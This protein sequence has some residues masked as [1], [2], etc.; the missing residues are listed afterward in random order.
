MIDGQ[1][2][3]GDVSGAGR[4][5]LINMQEGSWGYY[6]RTENGEWISYETFQAFPNLDLKDP[7]VK[8]VDLTGDGLADI[9]VYSEQV[10]TWF[11]SLGA[12]GYGEGQSVTQPADENKGPTCVFSDSEE[13]IYLADIS[14]DGLADLVRIRNGDV[15][16]WPSLGYCRFGAAVQMDNGPWFDCVDQFNENRVV[17]ADVDGS[18]TT[19]ILYLTS[20]GVDI[21]LNQ[22][23]NGFSE[24]KSLNFLPIDDQSSVRAVDLLGNG[25]TCLVWSTDL[26][27]QYPSM[28][29]V[30]LTRGKK[31]HLLTRS[32]NNLGAESRLYYAPSTKFYLQD[33]AKGT[34]WLTS[35]PFPVQCVEKYEVFDHISGNRFVTQFSYHHGYF[36]GCER[37]FR[38]FA[39]TEAWDTETFASVN[40]KAT[41]LDSSLHIPP[42]HTKT[43]FHCGSYLENEKLRQQLALEYF[44]A[45]ASMDKNA[46]D[47]FYK[48]LLGFPIMPEGDI[49]A[50]ELRES[51]RA[52]KGMAIRVES[53]ADDGSSKAHL[54]YNIIESNYIVRC[55]QP[56][57]DKN[58]HSIY[59]VA[60][61]ESITHHY[62]RNIE[63]PRVQHSIA[64]D[65]NYYGQVQKSISIGYGR[66]SGQSS[67]NAVDKLKQETTMFVYSET[68]FTNDV[69]ADDDYRMRLPY[70]SRQYELSGF[71]LPAGADRFSPSDFSRNDFAPISSLVEV[72]Y[73]Q[74]NDLMTKKKRLLG[75]SITVYRSD[76]LERLL[77]FG[78]LESRGIPGTS[79]T[80]CFTPGL[81]QKLFIRQIPGQSPENLLPSPKDVLQGTGDQQGGYV[82]LENNGHYWKKGGKVSFHGDPTA[83]PSAELVEAKGHFFKPRCFTDAFGNNS[84]VDYDE[85]IL[86]PVV[87]RDA[88]GN[89]ASLIM[90]YRVLAPRM[91]TNINGNRS[92]VAFDTLGM[93][94]ASAIMGKVSENLGDSFDNF[95]ADIS[96][97]NLDEFFANPRGQIAE[98]IL[99]TATMRTV[100]DV[101]RYY[102][103]PDRKL[104][105]YS[106]VISRES[107][108]KDPVSADGLKLQIAFSF[109]D[110]FSRMIQSKVPAK[111]GPVEDGGPIVSPRWTGTGWTVYNNKGK[112]VKQY[113]P[114]FDDTHDFKD[115]AMNGV[116]STIFYDPLGRAVAT[117]HPDHKV[118]KV[119]FDP[120]SQTV[121]DANDNVLL[122]DPR[123]DP[124]IGNFFDSLPLDTF[125]PSW[126]DQRISGQQG[127]D[128]RQAAVQTAAHAAT[129]SMT[130]L[131]AL[132]RTI[133]AVGDNGPDGL[134]YSRQT[135]DIQGHQL[136]TIDSYDRV[137][138]RNAF[139]MIGTAL[140]YSSMDAGERW[141]LPDALGNA[142]F[143]WN[144]R[145]YRYRTSYDVLRRPRKL[146]LQDSTG[147][148][149]MVE[150]TT[151]GDTLVDAEKNNIRGKVAVIRDQ[152]GISTT[153]AYDFKDNALS[154]G[155][156]LA[157]EYKK[158]LDWS[159]EIPLD[160]HIFRS[161][162]SFDAL[163]RPV[164]IVAPDKSKI[165]HVYNETGKLEQVFANVRGEQSSDQSTW[166]P[167][168]TGVEYDAKGRSILVKYGNGATIKNAFDKLTSNLRNFQ[169]T[170]ESSAGQGP[171]Q[172]LQYTYDA[173]GNM[174][175]IADKALPTVYFRNTVVD[176]SNDYKYDPL[177]RLIQS[178]GREHLGQGGGPTPFSST[179]SS[180]IGLSAPGDG[181]A[182]ARYTESYSYDKSNNLL[183]I[184]HA[185]SDA[186]KPGWTRTF[187]YNEKSIISPGGSAVPGV[188]SNRL[189]SSTVGGVTENYK[190]EGNAGI[191]G[192]MT[193]MPHLS[194]VSWDYLDQ[195]R[196]SSRQV[197]KNEG[198]PETTYYVYDT[199]GQRVRKVTERQSTGPTATVM[200]ERCY[201]GIFEVYREYAGDGTT[202]TLERESLEVN[203]ESSRIA[204]VETRTQGDTTAGP[205]RLI[206][207]HFG[208]A[209]DSAVLELDESAQILSYE[210]YTPYGSTSYQA[211]RSQTETP[212]RY[213]FGCKERDEENG[214][215]YHGARYYAPWL[216]KWTSADPAGLVDGM[217]VYC[218]VSCR[219]TQS[220]DPSG[221]EGGGGP[222]DFPIEGK[223]A[224]IRVST[225]DKL[226]IDELDA[227]GAK[228]KGWDQTPVSKSEQMDRA[229][230]ADNR[231][232]REGYDNTRKREFSL[233]GNRPPPRPQV[234]VVKDPN[235]LLDRRFSEVEELN[236]VFEEAKASVKNWKSLDP[237]VV[238]KRINEQVWEIIRNGKSDAA[239]KIRNAMA[240]IGIVDSPTGFRL[241]QKGVTRPPPEKLYSE[242]PTTSTAAPE[243]TTPAPA[244]PAEPVT[245]EAAATPAASEPVESGKLNINAPE[246]AGFGASGKPRS[247]GSKIGIGLAVAEGG[248]EIVNKLEEGDPA[249]ALASGAKTAVGI[250]LAE[251]IPGF[252]EGV[253]IYGI[254]KADTEQNKQE[255]EAAGVKVLQAYGVR[256]DVIGTDEAS[257]RVWG[258]ASDAYLKTRVKGAVYGGL[259]QPMVSTFSRAG[260]TIY[261]HLTHPTTYGIPGL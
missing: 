213:R 126:Y 255:A 261:H 19:D 140:Y 49:G 88:L 33:K 198:T 5:D 68:D 97:E 234:S 107:H 165:L 51:Y 200:K 174:I 195:M 104:P 87:Q 122:S 124:D 259:I 95:D 7:N 40:D 100:Y 90:D 141:V 85:N 72:P 151:Y 94:C 186:S 65:V 244:A 98:R 188:L 101:G 114:F 215:Y 181:T 64:L 44:G 209:L 160:E 99:G 13:T 121:Y 159:T 110:G 109:S 27:H 170:R 25:T 136:E 218:Y 54:P 103:E 132:G 223:R 57:Q 246:E 17:L 81:V 150:Q 37:E 149:V 247:V 168:L 225:T 235:A 1:A 219:P 204:L 118:D 70:E 62:E 164:V 78:I 128:E 11:P 53:Y 185:G 135:L 182:M 183:A 120:W 179:D 15:C 137:V 180:N 142:L 194:Q 184:K 252:G 240:I 79:Y 176:A 111:P 6:E 3:F 196:S 84:F 32:V 45:P 46:L 83:S 127:S 134:V 208:N 43:W 245:P 155:R 260:R 216:A 9:L 227:V 4:L 77:P 191:H 161:D 73:E 80:L 152:A 131:D 105:V 31:P 229:R 133:L 212:K 217:N 257:L 36:D 175:H 41:N 236:A 202:V 163:N 61:F 201:I 91:I 113:E 243:T 210:E 116:T 39:R 221:T 158:T 115:N 21:Y 93:V 22:S 189:S 233:V 130:H 67:L 48:S 89:T 214:L 74:V 211:V 108:S 238:K 251:C 177:Y 250:S 138:A 60:P 71:V 167:F 12:D 242:E 230:S 172:D 129:P 156:Q 139:D 193:S 75:R 232:I 166:T 50:D 55:L 199:S 14:G 187:S 56:L 143:A 146:F 231:V 173:I 20:D 162:C 237:G 47:E 96:Q 59:T 178:T 23:G 171:L 145:G 106:A 76:D 169:T 249:G 29:Y 26:P 16:Y 248:A 82:D 144:S 102:R 35:L 28:R 18:G 153:Y 205:A 119:V 190:Y 254:H 8:F 58:R 253:M 42:T 30:D 117:L 66:R 112:P 92:A 10:F 197:I 224:D 147:A 125:M 148:E 24:R 192:N 258:E 123:S 222:D 207:Y 256:T 86:F 206:R 154:S 241:T 157:T 34:P 63:D 226:V 239:V 2:R 203:S 52:L 69:I 38:G 228:F 220:S